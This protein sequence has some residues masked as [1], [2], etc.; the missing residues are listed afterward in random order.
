MRC[1]VALSIGFV[2]LSTLAGSEPIK[3]RSGFSIQQVSKYRPTPRSPMEDYAK[4]VLRSDRSNHIKEMKSA[5]RIIS[6]PLDVKYERSTNRTVS[7]V[8]EQFDIEY[9]SPVNVAGKTLNLVLDTGSAD[10]WVFSSQQP[11]AERSAH[12]YYTPPHG[13]LPLN[14][15]SWEAQYGEGSVAKGNVYVDKVSIVTWFRRCNPSKPPRELAKRLLWILI[16]M[17]LLDSLFLL[18]IRVVRPEKQ[19]GFFDNVK[20]TLPEPLFAVSL[21]KSKPGTFD[22]G[23]IDNDKYD[24]NIKYTPVHKGGFWSITST[25][26]V[27]GNSGS[28][29]T[30]IKGL[31]DTGTT[32]VLLPEPIVHD[33]HSKI[34]GSTKASSQLNPFLNGWIFPCNATI[35]SF[36]LIVENDYRATIPPE[37]IILQPFYVSGGS[38]MCFGSI[39]VAIHEIVFG[40]I[41]FK[42]QYV[43]F[44]TAGPRV[45]FA[46]Q[47][48]QK[49]GNE[50]VT[51]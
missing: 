4:A 20:D 2:W 49:L 51:G 11:L 5:P 23:F 10:L 39:Q 33:Y 50:V 45:G 43:V 21:K 25:G 32:M 13:T 8:P 26:Y 34:P 41:F 19:V 27:I 22:F 12:D 7:A 48:Q 31:L 46:R 35:Q 18:L 28:N 3:K 30:P 42:S 36:S 1:L 16:L 29:N 17:V 44:D 9:L 37:H 15:C 38:P 40:D 47:R 6:T 14:G 24:G